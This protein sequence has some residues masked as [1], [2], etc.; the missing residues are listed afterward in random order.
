MSEDDDLS[1]VYAL[2]TLPRAERDIEAH[3]VRLAELAG[4]EIARAWC[5]GLFE[6]IATLSDSPRT[7]AG[8]SWRVS[9]TADERTEDGPVV[10]L[11]HVRHGAQRPITRAQARE[12]EP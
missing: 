5:D 1:P 9:F 8:P 12:I 10:S 2:R 4:A 11:L 7:P 3:A 6:K